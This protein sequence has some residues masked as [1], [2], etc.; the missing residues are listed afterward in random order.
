[1]RYDMKKRTVSLLSA[2]TVIIGAFIGT[3]TIANAED[4][5]ETPFVP[6]VSDSSDATDIPNT[7]SE[8][9]I[10][11]TPNIPNIPEAP[12]IFEIFEASNNF[13]TSHSDPEREVEKSVTE[14]LRD[15]TC[16]MLSFTDLNRD[17]W[18]HDGI[19]YCIDNELMN[20]M[21]ASVFAPNAT[22]TRAM[23]VTILWRSDGEE[24]VDHVLPF[25]DVP[26][27]EWYTEAVRWAAVNGI[28]HGYDAE[29]FGPANDVTREQVMAILHRYAVYKGVDS[30]IPLPTLP[31]YI[32][33]RWAENDI[34]WADAV[35][36]TNIGENIFNMTATATRAE[37]ANY[38]M[39]FCESFDMR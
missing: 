6:W 20:G 3:A 1:M 5:N 17:A 16:P 34:I 35:G 29:T 10:S 37:I 14:C 11:Y 30:G 33:D 13:S 31:Q 32:Y 28:V 15:R 36:I 39:K 27:D 9:D 19:H 4:Q 23:L 18:Y 22:L 8:P 2:I 24:L 12:V 38:L 25:K 21:S 7:P 26:F